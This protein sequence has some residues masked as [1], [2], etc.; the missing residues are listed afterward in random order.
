MISADRNNNYFRIVEGCDTSSVYERVCAVSLEHL[1]Y[2]SRFK[3]RGESVV[4]WAVNGLFCERQ[5]TDEVS[6]VLGRMR[7]G[8]GK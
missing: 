2:Y 6:G 1:H 7:I 4:T 5:M 3:M 8:E